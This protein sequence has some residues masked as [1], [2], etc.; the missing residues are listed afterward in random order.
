[1]NKQTD[2]TFKP[3][4]LAQTAVVYT[5]CTVLSV[6]PVFA[7]VVST[8]AETQVTQA[9][10]GVPVVNIAKPTDSGL[11][12]NQFQHYNV[13]EKGLILNNS[14]KKIDQSQL[15]GLLQNN[16]NLDGQVAKKILNEVVGANASQLNGYT[17]VFGQSADVIVANPYGI[18]CN[19]CGFI[20]TPNVTL[21]TGT[22]N[23]TG[24]DLT[25]FNVEQGN[26]EI[27]GKGL[28]ATNQDYFSILSRTATLQGEVNANNL[29]IVTGKNKVEY[30]TN[31]VIE[32]ADDDNDKPALAIDA[33]ALG[34]MYAGRISLV[35][36]E[37]GVGVNLAEVATSAGDIVISAD[38]KISLSRTSSAD[39]TQI[40]SQTEVV[41]SGQHHAAGNTAFTATE[42]KVT[43][44]GASVSSGNDITLIADSV[45]AQ[46]SQFLAGIQSDG[47]LASAGSIQVKTGDAHLSSSTV[48]AVNK[49]TI[50]ANVLSTES[51]SDLAAK[52]VALK[53]AQILEGEINATDSLSLEGGQVTITDTA[54]LN[55]NTL[56]TNL[57]DALTVEGEIDANQANI[58]SKV[59]NIGESGTLSASNNVTITA[60]LALNNEGR[61]LSG[62]DSTVDTSTLK[63][64]GD[65]ISQG[66][67][68]L[69]AEQAN[70]SGLTQSG[71][72]TTLKADGVSL[73]S[74]STLLA[75]DTLTVNAA[76][77][78]NNGQ[79]G[80]GKNVNLTTTETLTNAGKVESQTNVTLNVTTSLTNNG[81]I[82][83]T[84]A[85]GLTAD[86]LNA[87]GHVSASDIT[88]TASELTLSNNATWHS[89]SKT[90]VNATT[91]N[92]LG[93][94]THRGQ[95]LSDGSLAITADS[96]TNESNIHANDS[97]T[98]T[99]QT[100]TQTSDGEVKAGEDLQLTASDDLVLSGKLNANQDIILSA[101]TSSL[102]GTVGAGR[103]ARLNADTVTLNGT[104]SA[105][106]DLTVST[107]SDK[108][109]T[110]NQNGA[111]SAKNTTVNA[112]TLN[113]QGRIFA[114][115]ALTA[116]VNS[117]SNNGALVSLGDATLTANGNVANTGLIYTKKELDINA[118]GNVS[119]TEADI[120]AD[121]DI[122]ISGLN[123]DTSF[124][125]RFDNLSGYVEA[126]NDLSIAAGTINNAR[127]VLVIERASAP[128]SLS[129]HNNADSFEVERGS[130]YAPGVSSEQKEYNCGRDAGC[131]VKTVYSYS[132][133]TKKFV[134]RNESSSITSMS[135]SSQLLSNGNLKLVANN[136]T[137]NASLIHADRNASIAASIVSN[138]GHETG[139]Y[140]EESTY[141]LSGYDGSRYPS[142]FT[143]NRTDQTLTSSNVQ[144][145][146]STI[147]AG[148]NLSISGSKN[149]TNS[150]EKSNA[151]AYN[152]KNTPVDKSEGERFGGGFNVTPS[153]GGSVNLPLGK[154]DIVSSNPVAFP[155]FALP[156]NPNGLFIY[157][158]GP[159]SQYLIETNPALTNLDQ[160]YGSEYFFDNLG[161]S[162][163]ADIKMLGDAYYDTR[164]I[165]QAIFEQ[166]G[167]RY[168][169][170]D[171]GGN[172]EQMKQLLDNAAQQ[173]AAY[174][175]T[176][177]I[178][179]TANQIN[180]LTQSMVWYE[181]VVVNGREVLAPKLYLASVDESSL[182]QIASVSSTTVRVEA[183]DISNSGS[184][185]AA[186]GLTLVSQ[187][188]IANIAGEMVGGGDT[189]LIA[190]NDIRN[191][192]GSIAGD[193]VSLTSESGNI[194]NQSF[195]QQQSVRKD[196]TVTTNSP[197]SDIVTTQTEVG[198]MASIQASGNLTLN[199]G[200]SINN[201]AAE[202]K[203][204][205]SASLNAGENIVIAAGELRTYDSFDGSRR[206]SADLATSTLAS[207]VSAGGDLTLNANNDIDVQ[208][209][210]LAAGDTLAL[211]AGNNISLT[212]SQ[213]RD[214][215][216][217][218]RYGKVDIAKDL[219][220]QGA[221]L[222]GNN[223]SLTAGG[224]ITSTAST[225][226][227]DNNAALK[228]DGD[229]ALLAA[230]DS[231]YRYSREETKKS[232]GRKKVEI[233]ES[234][235]ET[236]VGADIS[237]GNNITI[238][239]GDGLTTSLDESAISV[240]G[241]ALDAQGDVTLVADGDVTIQA[242][243]YREFSRHETIKKGFGGLSS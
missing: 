116:D 78:D 200:K 42:G 215:T 41:I 27:V 81:E 22:P 48:Q 151:N 134:T 150:V 241:S 31:R 99:T 34:G 172:L 169:T 38:G 225:I 5:L 75:G 112:G 77:L 100:Y 237:A 152:G 43:T 6:Q 196:G 13:T 82:K 61:I 199:A 63:Q 233:N 213:N 33:S 192:S 183:G 226:A 144:T 83:A 12:H 137:N 208:A 28:D 130:E 176:P 21:S 7:N 170:A 110:V 139:T 59:L 127:K 89:Q 93:Q 147:S 115:D 67:L 70:F 14:T 217:S 161:F 220:H 50:D 142:T 120:I 236:V 210:A 8:N 219:T 214:E 135:A 15:G 207:H 47:T 76:T 179:L 153:Q 128:I 29:A 209:S 55:A 102:N 65:L 11:S 117:L 71:D 234:L 160:F 17:E 123:G 211:A 238:Q 74:G 163:S 1:M 68:A 52:M 85:V 18:S 46:G 96:L 39:N 195:V 35:A 118:S 111:L 189:T 231:Q 60:S 156:S 155:A 24:G 57:Q 190:K 10:N 164:I 40:T 72:K 228:A 106:E 66:T 114:S 88:A 9:G 79:I 2:V 212:A 243:E 154:M 206:Q 86:T 141:F 25:G 143:Y 132:S 36:T 30:G 218:S 133:I 51:G 193:N 148:G 224:N 91:A 197:A 182:A 80:G 240:V 129:P 168:L 235:K 58:V 166:T 121:G 105:T 158:N 222:S 45:S 90:T 3:V 181:P 84:Q 107:A 180:Q 149:F 97:A 191:I 94:L 103:D 159:D 20:N 227:A 53:G 140:V 194:I 186:S 64:N 232:F 171:V 138:I 242:Q 174:N 239:A 26:V 23:I 173:T 178:A 124:A 205:E 216:S 16:P 221:A 19:G 145:L 73:A 162:P 177:G 146:S 101:G 92:H 126:G 187:N 56:T 188:E 122:T 175:L 32:T 230:N 49:V 108:T 185:N 69:T 104:L 157:S 201:T 204:G 62:A 184:I 198:D 119:N 229:I 37:K 167:K 136:I 44:S 131:R 125:N 54:S 203:A 113:N 87:N 109:L 202:L 95:L 165:S 4:S 98:I 223:V